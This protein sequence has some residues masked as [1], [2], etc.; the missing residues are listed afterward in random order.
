[1]PS[2]L[3]SPAQGP[4]PF[5][6]TV[7]EVPLPVS[8]ERLFSAKATG[9]LTIEARQGHHVVYLR[10][11]YPV[12]VELPGS[13]ELL[14]RVLVEMKYLDEATFQT[15]L[16]T[17]PPNGS[18]YGEMLLQRGLVTEEQLRAGLKAQVRRKLHRLFFLND[19]TIAYTAG[20]HSEG[21]Q[22]NES[23][24]VHPWRA[25][26]HGVRSAW[27]ADRLRQALGPVAGV[28]LRTSLTPEELARFGLGAED[29]K[30]ASLLRSGPHTVESLATATGVPIQPVSALC[31]ALYVASALHPADEAAVP[32]RSLPGT[33]GPAS[34]TQR[35]I[36]AATP[37]PAASVSPAAV[38]LQRL[39][40]ERLPHIDTDD[41]FTVLGV[42]RAA[43]T[44]EIKIA[45]LDAARRFHPVR[46]A[47]LGLVHL[48]ADVERIFRRVSEAQATL[49]PEAPRAKYL[50]SIENPVSKE[51]AAAHQ[52]VLT[53]LQGEMAFSR[54]KHLLKKNELAAALTDFETALASDPKEG[55]HIIYAAWTRQCLNRVTV[56]EAKAEIARGLKLTARGGSGQ[57]FLGMLFKQE[58][59]VEQ[60]MQAFRRAIDLDD[61]QFEAEQEIRVLQTRKPEKRGLFER[62]RKPAK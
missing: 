20:E 15:T 34:I 27:N 50:Q 1:M 31:Y 45:Y 39:V 30:V 44:E 60:A 11:G 57:Y 62:F 19:A 13:F 42:S 4:V 3:K 53:A 24:R 5:A 52:Q 6:S 41:L 61:R 40:S 2:I 46:L 37:E 16:E 59:A 28:P 33:G 49:L 43:T 25:N 38:E 17:P 21:L 26:Y 36:P 14:G 18:R 10:D 47:A 32:S 55:E 51:D 12:S 9:L 23:L 8:L 7:A 58:G 48:R 56:A 29:G 54:G 22:K 35:G